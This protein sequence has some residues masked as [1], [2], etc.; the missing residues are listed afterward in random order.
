MR[1]NVLILLFVN[2]LTAVDYIRNCC[3]MSCNVQLAA[4]CS[5]CLVLLWW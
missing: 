2:R 1:V 3:V 5:Q 4:F